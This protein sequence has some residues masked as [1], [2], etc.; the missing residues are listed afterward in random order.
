[1][2]STSQ[3]TAQSSPDQLSAYQHVGAYFRDIRQHYR[4]SVNQVSE[5]LHIRVKYIEAIERGELDELPSKVYAKGYIRNYASFLGLNA[6]KVLA[7]YEASG[8]PPEPLTGAV[9][10]EPTKQSGVPSF[11]LML[12]AILILAGGYMAFQRLNQSSQQRS[13]TPVAVDEVPEYIRRQAENALVPTW[14]NR[15]CLSPRTK[16]YFPP[17][18]YVERPKDVSSL[19]REAP[20]SIMEIR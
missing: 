5:Q 14:R 18:Y 12:L 17:C 10:T 19:L 2:P 3:D 8:L 16:G 15:A 20:Q 6:E 1:M 7:E 9:V 4:L 13:Q 11:G